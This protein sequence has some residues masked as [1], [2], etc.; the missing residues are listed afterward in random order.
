[1][2]R[3]TTTILAASALL[4]AALFVS[5]A[6]CGSVFPP[7]PSPSFLWAGHTYF[8]GDG[9]ECVDSV[10]TQNVAALISAVLRAEPALLSEQN[11][12]S[13]YVANSAQQPELVTVFLQTKPQLSHSAYSPLRSLLEGAASSVIAP[14]TYHTSTSSSLSSLV[15]SKL[16]SAASVVVAGLE[17]G[18]DKLKDATYIKLEESLNYLRQHTDLFSNGRT[19]LLLVF[20]HDESVSFVGELNGL[21][22]EA[23]S[24]NYLSVFS[25]ENPVVPPVQ[26]TSYPSRAETEEEE[27]ELEE[28]PYSDMDYWPASVWE[29]LI[30]AVLLLSILFFGVFC[31]FRVQVPDALGKRPRESKKNN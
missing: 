24:G 25:A 7:L 29:G 21:V 8:N 22:K 15:L 23:S 28:S 20:L 13:G 17:E 5:A 4:L 31:T 3:G 9:V 30:T 2:K 27:E 11:P 12:L 18:K 26:S 10:N 1:M 6:T 14:Y 19:D 16:P